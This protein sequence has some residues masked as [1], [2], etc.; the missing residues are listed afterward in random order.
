MP[1]KVL[2]RT[3]LVALIYIK[4][5]S[6]VSHERVRGITICTRGIRYSLNGGTQQ[7]IVACELFHLLECSKVEIVS[8]WRKHRDR[9][10]TI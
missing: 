2:H 4:A 10:E 7:N 9:S 1:L 6:T 3:L 8:W 5:S